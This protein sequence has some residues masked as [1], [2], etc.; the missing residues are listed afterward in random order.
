MK[1]CK[2]CNREKPY[3][4][5]GFAADTTCFLCR[6]LIEAKI[7]L[8]SRVK[9]SLLTLHKGNESPECITCGIAKSLDEYP[10]N[11]YECLACNDKRHYIE[12]HQLNNLVCIIECPVC[13]EAKDCQH[14]PLG[15]LICRS[16]IN[17]TNRL[18][19][20]KRYL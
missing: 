12:S 7:I 19:S 10:N 15:E 14:F 3:K 13:R 17:K 1:M 20:A 11:S 9:V 18:K 16:C 6:K 8:S 2:V 4:R 5:F